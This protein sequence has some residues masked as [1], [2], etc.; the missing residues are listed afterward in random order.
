MRL[1]LEARKMVE[2]GK[3]VYYMRVKRNKKALLYATFKININLVI[4]CI[5]YTI[6]TEIY[7]E[8]TFYFEKVG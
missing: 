7:R 2:F 6:N 8:Y 5:T 1:G 3:G 4:K